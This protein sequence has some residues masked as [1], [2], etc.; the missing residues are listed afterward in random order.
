MSSFGKDLFSVF[1]SRGTVI[2][3]GLVTS[4]ITARYLGPIG[5]GIVATLVIYPDLFMV[6]GSL[7]LRQAT[8]YFIG[9][10]KYDDDSLFSA[11]MGVWVF[12][13]IFSMIVCY[14]LLKYVTK[15]EFSDK[16]I[17]L[18]IIPIPF[19]LF[20]T[21]C[22]G[23]FLGKN[24]IKDF[25]TINWVPNVIRLVAYVIFLIIVPLDIYGALIGILLS[26]F[27]MSFFVF[28]KVRQFVKIKID[29]NTA[30]VIDLV[31]LGSV[32][33]ISLLVISLNYKVDVMLL[34]RFSTSNQV[35]IYT[36]GVSIVEYIWEVPTLLS[37]II[38]ARSANAKNNIDFSYKVTKLLRICF[39]LISIMS[40]LFYFLSNTLMVTMYGQPF[41]DSAVV[42]KI[43]LPGILLLTIFKVLNMDLAGQGK[44]WIAVYAMLPGLIINVILNVAWDNKFGAN[45]AAMASTISYA[46]SAIIFLFLYSIAAKIPIK[47]IVMIRKSDFN[48]FN[49]VKKILK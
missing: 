13:S 2:I 14:L 18:A 17:A 5:N 11:V 40:V 32:Y 34:E 1:K 16:L 27:F 46:V 19:A 4:I 3:C 28:N 42:Q 35:G 38:F 20:N 8:A 43:L 44:P 45:G 33:A 10:N 41:A 26:Y 12:S 23:I 37:T 7:G 47:N 25:N 48:F 49:D 39:V 31:K 24:K 29:W 21:Y 22:S 36:K 9:K 15:S 6:V 30:I